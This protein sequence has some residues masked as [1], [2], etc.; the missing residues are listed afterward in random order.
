MGNL[1]FEARL[2]KTHVSFTALFTRPEDTAGARIKQL[3]GNQFP[4]H[5]AILFDDLGQ[6]LM[7]FFSPRL[8][9][10]ARRNQTKH[11]GAARYTF[12]AVNQ[13]TNLVP[14]LHIYIAEICAESEATLV[15]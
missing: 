4:S 9:V 7:F 15:N 6:Y 1:L 5:C 10:E 12:S 13:A 8:L 11:L 3:L 2:Q 14:Y